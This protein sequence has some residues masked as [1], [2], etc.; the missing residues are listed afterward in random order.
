MDSSECL[1][2]QCLRRQSA[3][4]EIE[5]IIIMYYWGFIRDAKHA[6]N[7]FRVNRLPVLLPPKHLSVTNKWYFVR[8]AMTHLPQDRRQNS[9]K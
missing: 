5:S 2:F 1:A 4:Y 9:L 3:I 8:L 7:P 6:H